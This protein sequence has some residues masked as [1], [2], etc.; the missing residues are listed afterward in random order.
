LLTCT[1]ECC[2]LFRRFWRLRLKR[3]RDRVRAGDRIEAGLESA[4]LSTQM[5]VEGIASLSATLRT[6]DRKA[7]N[8]LRADM[9]GSVMPIAKEIAGDV[10]PDG[11][12]IWDDALADEVRWEPCE[13][14]D[15]LD[16]SA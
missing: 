6:L 10:P 13:W 11:S 8:R 3:L 15:S 9:R 1:L 12:P 14:C 16:R 5:R 4:L 7:I 2:S